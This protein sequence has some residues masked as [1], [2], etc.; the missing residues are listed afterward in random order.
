M[1]STI[2]ISGEDNI[3]KLNAIFQILRELEK[4][5]NTPEEEGGAEDARGV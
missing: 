2:S 1:L 4:A 3:A 5:A